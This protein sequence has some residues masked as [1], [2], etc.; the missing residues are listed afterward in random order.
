VTGIDTHPN[1]RRVAFI[2]IVSDDL[3]PYKS[4]ECD[5]CVTIPKIVNAYT[6]DQKSNKELNT[7]TDPTDIRIDF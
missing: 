3:K 6:C 4:I 2:W 5:Y 1:K 7:K